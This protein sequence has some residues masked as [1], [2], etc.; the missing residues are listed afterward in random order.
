MATKTKLK[1]SQNK[2]I[3]FTLKLPLNQAAIEVP[4]HGIYGQHTFKILGG[5]H[6]ESDSNAT[7]TFKPIPKYFKY[8]IKKH[9]Y[10]EMITAEESSFVQ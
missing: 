3:C 8:N 7:E 5:C 6:M 10:A 2:L 4:H 1:V 9:M